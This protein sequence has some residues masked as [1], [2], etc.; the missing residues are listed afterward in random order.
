MNAPSAYT[1]TQSRPVTAETEYF[2]ETNCRMRDSEY[3]SFDDIFHI[4]ILIVSDLSL[5]EPDQGKYSH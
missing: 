4:T 5:L 1:K 3:M 2:N